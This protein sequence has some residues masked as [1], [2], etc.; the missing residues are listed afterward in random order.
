[1]NPN[2]KLPLT[3]LY[4]SITANNPT[5]TVSRSKFFIRITS[6]IPPAK[7]IL[8]FCANAPKISPPIRERISGACMLPGPDSLDFRSDVNTL[9]SSTPTISAG[10]TM[11]PVLFV[12]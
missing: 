7:H 12:T 1:M 10:S 5:I 9:S 3:R 2:T 4:T 6:R 8:D 11:P